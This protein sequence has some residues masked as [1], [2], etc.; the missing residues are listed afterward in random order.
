[1]R[2][3]AKPPP[4]VTAIQPAIEPLVALLELTASQRPEILSWLVTT[5]AHSPASYMLV[6]LAEE[7]GTAPGEVGRMA[8]RA[9]EQ[10][11]LLERSRRMPETE[12][13]EEPDLAAMLYLAIERHERI[14][15]VRRKRQ[16][17]KIARRLAGV[18]EDAWQRRRIESFIGVAEGGKP[19]VDRRWIQDFL[20]D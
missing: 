13:P 16:L 14:S 19:A 9:T 5:A 15:S 12:S 8:T 11:N 6:Q 17:K 3:P 2:P 18:L 1:M 7:W 20:G 4:D 10:L